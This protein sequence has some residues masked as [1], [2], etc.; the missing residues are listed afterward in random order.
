MTCGR[1]LVVNLK[2]M[3]VNNNPSGAHEVEVHYL[4]SSATN[5]RNGR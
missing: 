2:V 1:P 4:F 3:I 5:H